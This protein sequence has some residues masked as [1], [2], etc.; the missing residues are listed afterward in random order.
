MV[1]YQVQFYD[2]QEEAKT[3][4]PTVPEIP[5]TMNLI[6]MRFEF[7]RLPTSICD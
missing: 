1:E 6:G 4:E 7:Y 2:P 3:I 5:S